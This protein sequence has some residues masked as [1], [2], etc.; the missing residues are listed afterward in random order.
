[1]TAQQHASAWATLLD[2][3]AAERPKLVDDFLHRLV[4]TRLYG[5]YDIPDED[6]RQAA[7]DTMNMLIHQIGGVP[8]PAELKNLP[9][10]L[11][12]RRARQGIPRENL[13]EAV[14]LD[15]RVLWAGLLRANADR[16]AEIL[17][18]HTEELLS[19]VETYISEV[20][21]SYLDELAA[22]TRDS[23][24]EMTR[25]FSRLLNAGT[26]EVEAVADEVAEALR[27]RAGADFE[28]TSVSVAN[29]ERAQRSVAADD[30][31]WH[32]ISWD[33]EDG[34]TFVR[35]RRTTST[36]AQ[37]LVDVPGGLVEVA[38]GLRSVPAAVTL[39]RA[40]ARH[41]NSAETQ[42]ATPDD[43]WPCIA[44]ERLG[45]ILPGLRRQAIG[46]VDDLPEPD[47]DRLLETVLQFCA[48]GS[49][50]TTAELSYCHRNTIVNRL[51]RFRDLTG[52]DV[53]VPIDA[54]QAIIAIGAPIP[55]PRPS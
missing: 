33:F 15:F 13:I 12:K 38:H 32:Y 51:L 39:A 21:A 42:L 41:C 31:G 3:L 27:F 44:H 47:R 6:L 36:W 48:N 19:I 54:A 4:E 55:R 29:T 53:T 18:L 20:Q 43:V 45:P 46:G 22:L 40:V 1:M 5:E 49:I 50:K 9:A 16:P 17:V 11:G 8:L 35:E 24:A 10:R 30:A 2:R 25:A 37:T 14:R 52:L 23:R 7:S 28:V 26:D 34:T